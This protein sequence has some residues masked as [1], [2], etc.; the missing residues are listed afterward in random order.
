MIQE[1]PF[2]LLNHVLWQLPALHGAA[3]LT[4]AMC[5]KGLHTAVQPDYARWG[6]RDKDELR[7]LCG[8]LESM[9]ADLILSLRDV[10]SELD[11][12]TDMFVGPSALLWL[13]THDMG[14]RGL[15]DADEVLALLAP[16]EAFAE[17]HAQ[18]GLPD[19]LPDHVRSSGRSCVGRR[20]AARVCAHKK[21]S[22]W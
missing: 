19:T 9:L 4:L 3:V 7:A 20:R 22:G 16:F 2:D 10:L 14:E 1:L 18:E 11:A 5:S 21:A 17:L 8:H 12:P 6:C 15:R 13:G